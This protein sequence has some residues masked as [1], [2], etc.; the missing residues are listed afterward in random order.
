MTRRDAAQ[1]PV[2]CSKCKPTHAHATMPL[3]RRTSQGMPGAAHQVSATRTG[4]AVEG[5]RSRRPPRR[6][7][8]ARV[9]L[10]SKSSG[11]QRAAQ[12]ARRRLASADADEELSSYM[13]H[14]LSSSG[15]R[16]CAPGRA[17]SPASRPCAQE[18]RAQGQV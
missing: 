3:S 1:D 8:A 11:A 10:R 7:H 14:R 6:P 15:S 12:A 17:C 18:R 4:R 13:E 2:R 5:L 16:R 9:Q